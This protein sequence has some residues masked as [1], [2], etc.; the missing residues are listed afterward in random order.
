MLIYNT[1]FTSLKTFPTLSGLSDRTTDGEEIPVIF[2]MDMRCIEMGFS[3]KPIT[4]CDC[5]L[6]CSLGSISISNNTSQRENRNTEKKNKSKKSI[7]K[8]SF[9]SYKKIFINKY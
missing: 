3:S 7:F 9:F 1:I 4:S 5:K 8:E 6:S 2:L